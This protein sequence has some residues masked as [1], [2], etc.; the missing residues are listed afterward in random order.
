MEDDRETRKR[1][2]RTD[3]VIVGLIVASVVA[4]LTL[5]VVL[6]TD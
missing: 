4:I 3:S 5:F 6:S 1:L 2:Q